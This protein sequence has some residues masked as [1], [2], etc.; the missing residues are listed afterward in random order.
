[1]EQ[2]TKQIKH[3]QTHP[4]KPLFVNGHCAP[5]DEIPAGDDGA[6]H[7]C[8]G[9]YPLLDTI[10]GLEDFKAIP[11]EQLD[12]LARELREFVVEHVSKSGG[13]LASSLGTVEM[14]IAMH[15]VFDS[16]K[17]KIVF[18]V[19]HQAYVHKIL[20]GRREAFGTLR[21]KDG[22]SGFPKRE[23]SIHDLFNTGHATTSI[24]AALGMAR[25]MKL[26]GQEGTAVAVIGDGAMTGGMAFEAINDAGQSELP[27]VILLNDNDMSIAAN[28]G[29]LHKQLNEMRISGW[30]MRLKRFIV[31]SLDSGRIG[32]WLTEHMFRFKNRVKNFLMPQ[33]FFEQLGLIYLGPIDGH[34]INK[35]IHVMR[36]AKELKL[37]VLVHCVTQKGKGYAFSEQDPVKFHGVAPFSVDTG[38]VESVVNKSNSNVFCDALIA[39]AQTDQ[40]IVAI[41]AA[42]PNGTGLTAFAKRFPDRFFDVGIAEEHAVTMA[43]GLAAGGMR[44]VVA[45]YS[46]FLQRGF[47]QVLHDV[48]LMN[49]PVVIAVDRAGLVGE[50]GETHQGLY[51]SAMLSMM[52]NMTVY[53]PASQEELVRMLTLAISRGEPAAIRYNRGRLMHL[54]SVQ[55]VKKGEWE[56]LEPISETTVIAPG[57]MVRMAIPVAR[58]LGAG[59]INARTVEPMDTA[60]LEQV[61]QAAR[62]VV[63]IEDGVDCLGK[64]VAAYLQGVEVVRM[65]VPHE[66]PVPQGTVAQQREMCGLTTEALR[67]ALLEGSLNREPGSEVKK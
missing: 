15:R 38:D 13:H 32:H 43:A 30:Y 39:L 29:V 26:Q 9:R 1:M 48:C 27:I 52:P 23:E 49:L 65:H 10:D 40:R 7:N 14:I 36:R 19:G 25:A 12:Q 57:D 2:Q 62:R 5:M 63:V 56:D 59:L 31:R 58:E 42:M 41:T 44:P 35:L 18:D 16:P 34:D 66:R 4:V 64:A 11:V 55:P 45:L 53:S 8:Q 21:Q 33:R 46:T 3:K 47:D 54:L 67:K 20:T 24:S 37:P 22:I 61:K 51:D 6:F 28:V 17:D 50:D 60:M